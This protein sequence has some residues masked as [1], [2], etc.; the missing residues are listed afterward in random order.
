MV[1]SK[2]RFVKTLRM[3]AKKSNQ[4]RKHRV[5]SG[6]LFLSKFLQHGKTIASVWPSSR[7]LARATIKEVD[8]DK[9]RVI[10]ELGAG[11]GAITK[12]AVAR[13]KPHTR[14]LA[15]ERDV[16]F[17]GVLRERFSGLKN[18]E[19]IHGDVCEIESILERRHI[20]KV[21]YFL[22]GLPTPHLPPAVRKPMLAGVRKYMSPQG[23]YSNIT[24][25]PLLYRGHYRGWFENVEFQF[26]PVNI[27]PGG[28]YHCRSAMDVQ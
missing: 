14:L 24:E 23:V 16:D 19:I 20:T 4:R 18:V 11:T 13:L 3:D 2:S 27:P 7:M 8:W 9:A 5:N 21:D 12:E 26:V 10:V 6:L 22:S 1:V 25:V 17:V 28:V 15:I